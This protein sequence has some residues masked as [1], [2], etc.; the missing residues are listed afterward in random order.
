MTLTLDEAHLVFGAGFE[1][2]EDPVHVGLT[3]LAMGDRSAVEFAKCSHASI[4]LQH[5]VA[6]VSEMMSLH[7]AIPRGLLRVGAVDYPRNFG[8]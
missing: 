4:L 3:T 7:G 6:K 5:D 2:D 1:W 8:L